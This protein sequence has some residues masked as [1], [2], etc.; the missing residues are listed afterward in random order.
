M[1][2]NNCGSSYS[3]ISIVMLAFCAYLFEEAEVHRSFLSCAYVIARRA[4]A[5]KASKW[6]IMGKEES[7][8]RVI[9]TYDF[10]RAM[11]I[12]PLSPAR[13]DI[14]RADADQ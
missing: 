5:K 12:F 3:F 9:P 8:S 10:S 14:I 7:I 6:T 1:S 13:D 2:I 11:L 4:R